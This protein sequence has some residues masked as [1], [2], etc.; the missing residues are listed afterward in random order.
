M[1]EFQ[2][3][4]CSLTLTVVFRLYTCSKS[5]R[6]FG[7]MVGLCATCHIPM[8]GMIDVHQPSMSKKYPPGVLVQCVSRE[9]G[10]QKRDCEAPS[11][12]SHSCV[13]F[14]ASRVAHEGSHVAS[15]LDATFSAY[16]LLALLNPAP[17]SATV[18]HVMFSFSPPHLRVNRK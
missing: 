17:S 13:G 3:Q 18:P 10:K 4:E 6:T 12:F 1:G 8:N 2:Q 16:P 5:L 7:I 9:G 15:A 14:T 11:C